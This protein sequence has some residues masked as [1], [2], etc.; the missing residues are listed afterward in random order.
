[1]AIQQNLRHASLDT[2]LRYIGDLHIEQRKPPTI[3]RPNMGWLME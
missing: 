1:V 3:L 2:T